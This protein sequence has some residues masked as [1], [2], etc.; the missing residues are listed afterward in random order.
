[1]P[2]DDGYHCNLFVRSMKLTII[3]QRHGNSQLF[4]PASDWKFTNKLSV[5][6][7]MSPC[8]DNEHGTHI[9]NVRRG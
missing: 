2:V 1:M 9:V 4:I 3:Y 6:V 8:C 5:H 7:I